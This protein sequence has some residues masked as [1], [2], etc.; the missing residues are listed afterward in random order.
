MNKIKKAHMNTFFQF[1][2]S[3]SFPDLTGKHSTQIKENPI[4]PVVIFRHLH[5]HSYLSSIFQF[6][7][8][9]QDS[10]FSIR[11]FFCRASR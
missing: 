9:I 8:H 3:I 11:I 6:D 10:Q 4:S 2:V 5:F 7:Q 1:I